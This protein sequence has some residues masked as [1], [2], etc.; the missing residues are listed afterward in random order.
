[1]KTY[2]AAA[3]AGAKSY[4][5]LIL[6]TADMV[7]YFQPLKDFHDT[8]GIVTEIRTIADV[9]SNDPAMVRAYILNEYILEGIDYVLIGADDD[10]IPAKDLYVESW[11]GGNVITDM[12][13]DHYFACLDGDYN[14]DGD[15]RFGEPT[16]GRA[17]SDVD[18]LA[19]VIVGRAAV[20]N[21]VEAARFVDKTITYL[22]TTDPYL[23]KV[24]LCG[25]ELGFGG[26]SEYAANSLEELID[27][28][29]TNGV[30]TIGI[31]STNYD[32]DEL[33]DRDW[34]GNYWPRNELSNRANDDIHI[35][36]H[37][38]HG[39][40][41]YAMKFTSSDL[42]TYFSNTH[43]FFLYSQAC[44]SGH[45]DGTDCYAEYITIKGNYGAFAAIMNARYVW[46]AVFGEDMPQIGRANQDSKEDN[47]YRINE[48]CMRWCYYELNLLGDPTIAFKGAGDCAAAYLDDTDGDDV[49]DIFD[50]CPTTANADQVDSDGDGQGDLCD[51]C[52]YDPWDDVDGDGICGDV[53]N[54]PGFPNVG[55]GD[56]D[57]D[58]V[59]D[60]C[61]ICPGFDDTV[62]SDGDGAPDG[63]DRCPGFNDFA[64]AD[65]DDVPDGCD[66]CPGFDDNDDPDVDAIPSGCDNCPNHYNPDQLDADLDGI[67]DSCCC[68]IRG[69]INR[70]G[71]AILDVADLVYL[72]DYMFGTGA[73]PLC[74]TESD[75]NADGLPLVDVADLVYF[76]D[77]MFNSGPALQPCD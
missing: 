45:F 53:D 11:Q 39:S 26:I 42:P 43:H 30:F 76:V 4:D 7:T 54:C 5:M 23:K 66:A 64:D 68:V 59:G 25:E 52:P 40:S 16:D 6:T 77:F 1:M 24:L 62:D 48:S 19:E 57:G 2:S 61:D 63:C 56:A 17:G 50:N 12:P 71:S 22:T 44:L 8:T 75:I 32:V 65:I 41:G 51:V 34:S 69:D 20:G 18:L 46:D 14:S 74:H 15:D 73:A 10:L 72:T 38:G 70:S 55:Q 28:C 36:N 33:F 67:G 27:S 37:F 3:K 31:P 47:I 21:A 35:L 13:G 60:F 9:G 49:C 29:G 58:G